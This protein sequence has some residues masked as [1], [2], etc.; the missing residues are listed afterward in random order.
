MNFS[1]VL[2]KNI[3][4][5]RQ[6]K[7]TKLIILKKKKQHKEGQTAHTGHKFK[8]GHSTKVSRLFGQ[9]CDFCLS[10]P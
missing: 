3:D 1:R 10:V 7:Q 5:S 9:L 6:Q 8:A 4:L 2:K